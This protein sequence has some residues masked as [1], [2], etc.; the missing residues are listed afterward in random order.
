MGNSEIR[1]VGSLQL[2]GRPWRELIVHF[3][4][5]FGSQ[6]WGKVVYAVWSIFLLWLGLR[7][8]ARGAVRERANEARESPRTKLRTDPIRS[9]AALLIPHAKTR[10]GAFLT[11]RC[12]P[13][14]AG[15]SH[16]RMG[17]RGRRLQCTIVRR[18]TPSPYA[19]EY[20][21]PSSSQIILASSVRPATRRPSSRVRRWLSPEVGG[22]LPGAYFGNRR[23]TKM[24]RFQAKFG[25][26]CFSAAT[27][28]ATMKLL[29]KRV[30]LSV[31]TLLYDHLKS[32]CVAASAASRRSRFY[33]GLT[34]AISAP[35]LAW[36]SSGT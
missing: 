4:T 20:L 19:R 35:G 10:H 17:M 31:R 6:W 2:K 22:L 34:A 30:A 14:A 33:A 32:R 29:E 18:R 36:S 28:T 24:F 26:L 15:A 12:R 5:A 8:F 27:V 21:S 23:W 16:I 7:S 25:M 13:S 1:D 11:A 3:S 9:L